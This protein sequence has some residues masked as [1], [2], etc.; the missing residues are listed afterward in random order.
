MTLSLSGTSF[1][2]QHETI[3]SHSLTLSMYCMSMYCYIGFYLVIFPIIDVVLSYVALDRLI[4]YI[5]HAHINFTCTLYV[6]IHYVHVH[7]V[8]IHYVCI[9]CTV[10]IICLLLIFM[11]SLY[12]A[13]IIYLYS[14][15]MDMMNIH[16]TYVLTHRLIVPVFITHA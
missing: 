3:I 10:S 12:N 14:L 1:L 13:F 9:Q 11:W 8:N 6:C 4:S 15:F 5:R 7:Y 2:T 16:F